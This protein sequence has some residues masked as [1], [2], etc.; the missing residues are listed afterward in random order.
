MKEFYLVPVIEFDSMSC[1]PMDNKKEK[2]LENNTL[3]SNVILEIFNSLVKNEKCREINKSKL[4]QSPVDKNHKNSIKNQNEVKE[5]FSNNVNDVITEKEVNI[6]EK[7][8]KIIR[9]IE[10]P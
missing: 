10:K 8:L 7:I 9:L 4:N 6:P 3:S 5:E 1:K 2:I